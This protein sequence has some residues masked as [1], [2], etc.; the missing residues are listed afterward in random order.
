MRRADLRRDFTARTEPAVWALDLGGATA[1]LVASIP[2][3]DAQGRPLGSVHGLLRREEVALQLRADLLDGAGDI[4][5]VTGN[6]V[7]TSGGG[8]APGEIVQPPL[9]EW[10]RR[11]EGRGAQFS[12]SA[13][14]GWVALS[15]R[16][17]GAL[18]WSLVARQ[19]ARDAFGSLVRE[20]PALLVPAAVL[21][22]LFTSLA[23]LLGAR[24]TRPFA[25]LYEATRRVA[26]GDFEAR[27]PARGAPGELGV[28]FDAFDAMTSQ[29]REERERHHEQLRALTD[30][31]Q[32]FQDKHDVLSQLSMTDGLTG[33]NN[34]RYFQDQLGR[35]IKRRKR[36]GQ[37]LSM[38]LIDIDD[39]KQLNDRFGHAAGDEFLKQ[40][41]QILRESVRDTDLLA[42]Y[43]GEEFAIVATNTAPQGAAMLAEKL[44]TKIAETT[45]IVDA[46]M[47][48]R[49]MTISIGVASYKR[50]RTEFFA[51]AD[52]A[53]YRAKA[54]GKN[55]V[56]SADQDEDPV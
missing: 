34:H 52:A 29:L 44:C 31:N 36:S 25:A 13:D 18:D 11:G 48:P 21:I 38:L 45:F 33:L 47:R 10:L 54:A 14:A 37:V 46:S 56:I 15:S 27:L 16:P 55:C 4:Y 43:G 1:S 26:R 8:S 7:V 35:E 2:L 51:S 42:R 41:A 40:L 6:G 50:S 22:L 23:A 24:M 49:R 12:W 30:Q 5:L 19:S 9:H 28:L 17:V 39:F 3:R 20:A 32:V 53:L